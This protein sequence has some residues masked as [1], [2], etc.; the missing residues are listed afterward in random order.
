MVRVKR[1]VRSGTKWT[2]GKDATYYPTFYSLNFEHCPPYDVNASPFFI[3]CNRRSFWPD[4]FCTC[5]LYI[6]IYFYEFQVH[7]SEAAL[8]AVP[9]LPASAVNTCHIGNVLSCSGVDTPYIARH[10]ALRVGLDMGTPSLVVNRL[11]GSGFQAIVNGA[12]DILLGDAQVVMTGGSDNMSAAPYAA[13]DIR[14]GTKLGQD[15]KLEDM[16][17]A[18]LTDAYCKTPMGVTAENLAAKFGITRA[19]VN[20]LLP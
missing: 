19:D 13:R 14:F 3:Y 16:M 8:A 5:S 2:L 12:Q 15:P 17:W 10:T 6:L 11:C 20:I 7:A 4:F 18:S 9:N 1:L